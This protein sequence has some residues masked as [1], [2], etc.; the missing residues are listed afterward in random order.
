MTTFLRHSALRA[1]A[2]A[3]GLV[4]HAGRAQ[5]TVHVVAQSRITASLSC[6]TEDAD[7]LIQG[8]LEDE[9]GNPLSNQDLRFLLE[10]PSVPAARPSLKPCDDSASAQ[11]TNPSATSRTNDAGKFCIRVHEGTLAADGNISISFGGGN[12]YDAARAQVSLNSAQ[13]TPA[14]TVLESPTRFA[15]DTGPSSVV[16]QMS[17]QGR[18][19]GALPI[20]LE[21]LET[22]FRDGKTQE[23]AIATANTDSAGV[24]RFSVSRESLDKPGT[25]QLRARFAGTSTLRPAFVVWS[26]LRTCRVELQPQLEQPSAQVGDSVALDIAANSGCGLVS[27]GSVEVSLNRT[28][29][30]ALPLKAGR[31]R[32][33][34]STFERSPGEYSISV[35]YLPSSAGF[36]AQAP[37]TLVL[38][39]TPTSGQRRALWLVSAGLIFLWFAWRWIGG[40]ARRRIA[41][42]LAPNDRKPQSLEVEPSTT[43]EFGWV[44][45]L[46]DSHTSAP[47]EGGT[48]SVL[49]PSFEHVRTELDVT[50]R[51]DGSFQVS[52]RS[53]P[54]QAKLSVAAQGYVKA[55]WPMPRPGKL[56]VRL[57]TRR[58]ATLRA[59]V[60]LADKLLPR[61][62]TFAEPTPA[63]VRAM[64]EERSLA[65]LGKWAGE[66]EV[67]AFGPDES[68]ARDDTVL[69]PPENVALVT[70]QPR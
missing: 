5:V 37:Q 23:K 28:P 1:A 58:R 15:L 31:V 55:E 62:S 2:V 9:L 44:G 26:I 63:Q 38:R 22:A 27:E 70:K 24:A 4:S 33:R 59:F 36:V 43:P 8:S 32:W 18:S 65:E 64:A 68:V 46:F 25:A 16:V 50:T 21:L 34:I 42:K 40:Y 66:V 45:A 60:Q 7:C 49:I 30:A 51:S 29:Q 20:S 35:R 12:G 10:L 14:L 19:T 56:I 52:H 13:P 53:L 47:I 3:I 61:S 54:A 67:T 41:E 69:S 48:V 6:R 11:D 17:A 39:L 57:E